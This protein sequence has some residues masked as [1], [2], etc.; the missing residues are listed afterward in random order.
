MLGAQPEDEDFPPDG[1]DDIDPDH[2]EFLG[3]GQPGQ[4]PAPPDGPN[5]Q[6]QFSVDQGN[7][8]WAPWP[9]QNA[10]QQLGPH[11][12][13][14]LAVHPRLQPNLDDAP[15][16]IPIQQEN[17]A[18][19]DGLVMPIAEVIQNNEPQAEDP[20]LAEEHVL[21]MDDD[22]DTD[23]DVFPQAQLPKAPVEIVPFLDFNNMQPL[24]PEEIQEEEL[25]GWINGQGNELKNPHQFGDLG[26]NGHDEPQRD[27]QPP[28][29]LGQQQ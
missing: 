28:L 18:A 10:T 22:T 9:N 21:A 6:N 29:E 27:Q 4:G 24:M 15:L 13:D 12:Q 19:E 17:E 5:A 20:P 2:F 23:S 26:N 14:Q 3:Y 1:L 25:L 16:L 8:V 11:S 7:H